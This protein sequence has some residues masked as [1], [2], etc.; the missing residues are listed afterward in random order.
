MVSGVLCCVGDWPETWAHA[1]APVQAVAN[2]QAAPCTV[3]VATNLLHAMD[4][5]GE[6]WA[7]LETERALQAEAQV[8]KLEARV[9]DLERRLRDAEREAARRADHAWCVGFQAGWVRLR[10]IWDKMA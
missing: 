10:N 3:T 7:L 8:A 5:L 1:P 9:A 4:G 6:Q 2:S